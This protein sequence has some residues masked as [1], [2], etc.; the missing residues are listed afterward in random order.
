MITR[1]EIISTARSWIGTPYH[2]QGSCRGVGADC[3]GLVRGVWHTLYGNAA[4]TPPVYTRDWA[5]ASGS[6]T[7]IAAATRHLTLI[8]LA[9]ARAG[10]VIVFRFR[11]GLPAK[12]VGILSAANQFVHA[13]E[14]GPAVEIALTPWWRRRIVAAF[15]FPGV[16][17]I[18]ASD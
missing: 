15:A 1:Q 3:L 13:M 17:D 5:E 11:P 16:S 4:E 18:G 12:H 8:P 9:D 10:D 14:G 7:L 2:H 6:E